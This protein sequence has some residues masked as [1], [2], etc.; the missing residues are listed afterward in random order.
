MRY[1]I[2]SDI[3]SN[4]EALDR[5]INAYKNESIDKY[6]CVGDIVG[7]AANPNES[8]ERV[9]SLTEI[10][11]AGNHDWA[12]V[13]L[14][15]TQ[16]FNPV[17]Y[18]A[19]AWTSRNLSENNKY[20]LKNLKL[21]YEDK[22]LTLVHGTLNKPERFDYMFNLFTAGETFRLMQSR[23]CFIGHTHVAGCF[24]KHKDGDLDYNTKGYISMEKGNQ[25]IINVGSVGQPRGRIP[26]AT[27]CIYDTDKKEAWI[28][29]IDY[30]IEVARK[31]I[32]DAGLPRF[33]AD[34]LLSGM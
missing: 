11:I 25:Y 31:K 22:E 15:S 7:Y 14:F 28:K 13:G 21:V 26:K 23:I 5:V 17:A 4:L 1:G 2:F 16:Y 32:I 29:R 27:Y 30:E 6:L 20:F 8:I 33:L 9:R 24:I 18:E 34:R 3:H 19:I 10:S 12:A